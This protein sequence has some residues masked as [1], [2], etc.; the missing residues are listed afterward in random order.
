M[1]IFDHDA[2]KNQALDPGYRRCKTKDNACIS[3]LQDIFL[4]LA[5]FLFNHKVGLQYLDSTE[6]KKKRAEKTFDEFLI[7]LYSVKRGE[8]L[9][10]YVYIFGNLE[11]RIEILSDI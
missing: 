9:A 4:P 6:L 5:W 7:E 3:G 10:E 8:Q 2:H 1:P 11:T